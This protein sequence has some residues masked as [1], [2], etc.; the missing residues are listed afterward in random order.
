[1]SLPVT[2]TIGGEPINSLFV[3]FPKIPRLNRKIVV[4]EKIDGT[5]ASIIITDAGDVQ[6]A[7]RTRLISVK[8]DNFGFAAWVAEHREEL[9]AGLGPGRH[10]GEWWG[11][12]IQRNY[13]QTERHFSLFNVN[14]WCAHGI[15]P[16]LITPE[17]LD[18]KTGAIIRPA[19]Y[20]KPAPQ[21]C[22]VVPILGRAPEFSS[23]LLSNVLEGLA[24]YG[25]LAA[26]GWMKPEGL[27][28]FH[29]ASGQFFKVTCENDNTPK[30]NQ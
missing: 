20:Q 19:V 29:E 10:F 16:A 6:A 22:R 18:K 1:M 25:S 11:R 8:S 9:V 17:I 24:I 26:P 13:G 30:S 2:A 14:R 12:G 4:T 28:V 23:A 3:P 21:C 5:N 15:E 7:S 27:V